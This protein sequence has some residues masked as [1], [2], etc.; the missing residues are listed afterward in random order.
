MLNRL[1]LSRKRGR[2]SLAGALFGLLLFLGSTVLL[3]T[4]E[5]RTDLS[6]IARDAVIV[7]PKSDGAAAQGQLVA[8]TGDL[9]SEE[10]AADPVYRIGGN[11]LRLERQVEMYA[12]VEKKEDDDSYSYETTWTADPADSST[13][14]EPSAPT[15]PTMPV[16]DEVF[17]AHRGSVGGFHFDPNRARLPASEDVTLHQGD[18]DLPN[19]A[20]VVDGIHIYTGWGSP[21]RPR[22]GDVRIS[23][24]AVPAGRTATLYGRLQNDRVEAYL[25]GGDKLYGVWL[26]NHDEALAAMHQ[27]Y[28]FQGWALRV[29][30]LVMMWMGMNLVFSPLTNLLGGIPLLG[31]LSRGLVWAVTFIVSLVLTVVIVVVSFIAHR[32]YLLLILLALVL[33]G[34]A[35][36]YR[37]RQE[38]AAP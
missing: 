8:I 15:N 33:A 6:K 20:R 7:S 24:Q 19:G 35:L 10:A 18:L 13:F 28:V 17:Y 34:L 2:G 38:E 32:W 5:G 26:G 30:G 16:H 22:V 14:H 37:K 11:Y 21:A 23:Y 3:W 25:E 36:L 31:D 27:A 29:G 1:G 4:N 12:W 9:E